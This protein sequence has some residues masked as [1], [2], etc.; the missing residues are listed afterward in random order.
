MEPYHS[1]QTKLIGL[2]NAIAK[3]NAPGVPG[4]PVAFEVNKATVMGR[5][6]LYPITYIHI[7]L[8]TNNCE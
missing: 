8:R 2:T 6:K 5:A 3:G 1:K 4:Y 7:L